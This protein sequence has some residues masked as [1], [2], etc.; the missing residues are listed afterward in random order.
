MIRNIKKTIF[1]IASAITVCC[2]NQKQQIETSKKFTT[3]EIQSLGLDS[4]VDIT[5]KRDSLIKIDLNS[6]LKEQSFD[7]GKLIKSIK[8]IPLQTNRNSLIS[9]IEHIII[10][11][12]HIYIGNDDILNNVLIFD[13]EGKYI[14]KIERGQ[15]PTEILKLNAIVYDKIREELIVKHYYFLSFYTKDGQFKRKEKIPFNAISFTI[16]EDGYL[17]Y[18]ENGIDNTHMGYPCNYQILITDRQFRVKAKGYPY[19]LAEDIRY[20]G[21]YI[22][23]NNEKINLTFVFKDTVYQYIDNTIKTKYC[24]DISKK[25]IPYG[26]LKT[27]SGPEF[28]STIRN[29]DYYYFL[30]RF[31]ETDDHIFVAYS[32]DYIRKRIELFIDKTTNNITGGTEHTHFLSDFPGLSTPIAVKDNYFISFIQP[33]N[34]IQYLNILNNPSIAKEDIEKLKKLVEDDNPVLILYD[35][36]SF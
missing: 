5:I 6:E 16:I 13:K 22:H 21:K 28:A 18:I 17:F 7:F 15:G 36:K 4:T 24:I 20:G 8:F 14:N 11:D 30:G 2:C 33:Y 26:I 10:T 23:V 9:N 29:H 31:E 35:L 3:E 1:I 32:N 19:N 25:K 27:A 12:S 34:F